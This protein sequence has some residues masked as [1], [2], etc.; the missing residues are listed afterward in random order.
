LLLARIVMPVMAR[1]SSEEMVLFGSLALAAAACLV[2][3]FITNVYMLAAI[4]FVLGLGLGCCG[5]LSLIITYNRAPEGRSGE[6]MGLRQTVAKFTESSSPLAFG[7]LGSAF[8]LAAMRFKLL[9]EAL[10]VLGS[11]VGRQ[12][13]HAGRRQRASSRL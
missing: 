2:F 11:I 9:T 1:K 10:L 12:H 4:S 8:G 7:A 13:A 6:A 5:P 3:P